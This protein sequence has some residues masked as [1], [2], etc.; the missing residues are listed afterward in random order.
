MDE[1]KVL[2][3]ARF[4]VPLRVRWATRHPSHG[5]RPSW[6]H[7]HGRKTLLSTDAKFLDTP[8]HMSTPLSSWTSLSHDVPLGLPSATTVSLSLLSPSPLSAPPHRAPPRV[9]QPFHETVSAL[10]DTWPLR[11]SLHQPAS[12]WGTS[13]DHRTPS[14]PTMRCPRSRPDSPPSPVFISSLHQPAL[15]SGMASDHRL[16]RLQ[17]CARRPRRRPAT[18]AAPDLPTSVSESI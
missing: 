12:P 3:D 15:A 8:P 11:V 13:F 14:P 10:G 9:S 1:S 4:W 7:A 17:P 6:V 16:P 5:A 2:K 18:A